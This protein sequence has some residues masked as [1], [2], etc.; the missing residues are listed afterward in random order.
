MATRRV[1]IPAVTVEGSVCVP[2]PWDP[3]L[4]N[5]RG[6]G[7]ERSQAERLNCFTPPAERH[8]S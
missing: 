2:G 6:E 3:R 7:C 4:E 8:L 5:P 1:W